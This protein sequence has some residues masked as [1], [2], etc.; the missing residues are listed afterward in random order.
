ME[1]EVLMLLVHPVKHTAIDQFV[2]I[3]DT[4]SVC[5]TFEDRTLLLPQRIRDSLIFIRHQAINA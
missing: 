5:Y 3:T 4:D 2:T 1:Q